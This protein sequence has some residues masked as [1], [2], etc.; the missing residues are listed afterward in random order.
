MPDD[1]SDLIPMSEGVKNLYKDSLDNILFLKRQQWTITNYALLAFAAVVTIG[2]SANVVETTLLTIVAAVACVYSI[3]CMVHTQMTLTKYRARLT[4]IYNTYFTAAERDVFKLWPTP[5]TFNYTPAFMWGLVIT[6][7]LAC[8]A[9]IYCFGGRRQ[10]EPLPN[11]NTLH[12]ARRLFLPPAHEPLSLLAEI[13]FS[14][15]PDT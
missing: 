10:P 14:Y 5:P 11:P 15:I 13:G 2:K 9:A 6:N 12:L 3:F 1:Q 7:V 4:H 8:A